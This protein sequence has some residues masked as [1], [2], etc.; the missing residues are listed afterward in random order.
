VAAGLVLCIEPEAG[1][2]ESHSPRCAVPGS[3]ACPSPVRE[4]VLSP[5]HLRVKAQQAGLVY[6]ALSPLVTVTVHSA[7]ICQAVASMKLLGVCDWTL[8]T[9]KKQVTQFRRFRSKI[10]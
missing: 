3:P 8:E 4:G 7:S 10:S 2:R 5:T 9:S 6:C 1:L